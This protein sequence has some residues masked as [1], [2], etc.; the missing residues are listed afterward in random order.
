[1]IGQDMNY[2]GYDY[3]IRVVPVK[4]P[5]GSCK[6]GADISFLAKLG[7]GKAT[8]LSPDIGEAL[9]STEEEASSKFEAKLKKWIDAQK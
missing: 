9:G 1:M 8:R 5:I 4:P 2:R 6:F 7:Q 3:V